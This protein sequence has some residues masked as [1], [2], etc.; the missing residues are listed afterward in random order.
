MKKVMI[1]LAFIGFL[2]SCSNSESY[3]KISGDWEC[4]S[5]IN[6]SKGIDKCKNN[7]RF[8]FQL[9]KSYYSELGN[10]KD[11]GS[12]KILND[13]LYVTPKGKMEFVVKITKLNNDTLEFLMNQAGEE[14]VLTLIRTKQ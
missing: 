6:K 1:L 10:T 14:E 8:E 12:F 4:T 2:G 9:D 13:M 7:V 5:W 3:E 11:S